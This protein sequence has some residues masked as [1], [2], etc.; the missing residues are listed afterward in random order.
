MNQIWGWGAECAVG[1]L[2]DLA[3][4]GNDSLEYVI[5]G[6]NR[7]SG[8]SGRLNREAAAVSRSLMSS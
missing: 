6:K 1:C 4:L 5:A 3:A 7:I 2:K 8:N